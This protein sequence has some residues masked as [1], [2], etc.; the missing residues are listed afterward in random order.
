[1][2]FKFCYVVFFILLPFSRDNFFHYLNITRSFSWDTN[3]ISCLLKCQDETQIKR[4][5]IN[6]LRLDFTVFNPPIWRLCVLTVC[7][8]PPGQQQR[9]DLLQ[10][11]GQPVHARGLPPERQQVLHRSPLGGRAQRH[12]RR[13]VLQ[14]DHRPG[15]TGKGDAGCEEVLQKPGLLH[16]LLGLHRYLAPSD[17][18]RGKPDDPGR[19]PA[20]SSSSS[21]FLSRRDRS[22]TSLWTNTKEESLKITIETLCLGT[23]IKPTNK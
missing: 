3:I 19:V 21:T 5:M 22:D 17:V 12:P 15:D 9:R 7:A 23:S 1:M 4:M 11:A 10:R 18:L 2:F 8:L 20:L 13:R 6:P 14:R 16:G